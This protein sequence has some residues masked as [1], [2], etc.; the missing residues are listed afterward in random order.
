M[1]VINYNPATYS[2]CFSNPI[3]QSLLNWLDAFSRVK[4]SSKSPKTDLQNVTTI[5]QSFLVVL[6]F[7]QKIDFLF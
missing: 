6:L 3:K 2:N 1:N 5:I 7:K 4:I